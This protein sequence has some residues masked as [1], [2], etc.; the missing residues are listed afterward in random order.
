MRISATLRPKQ[1]AF[2]M[3]WAWKI[4]KG[5]VDPVEVPP[6]EGV[7]ICWVHSSAP[8]SVTAARQMVRAFGMVQVAALNSRHID[9]KAVD[10]TIAWTGR[11]SIDG[12]DG[13]KVQIA[14]GP[15]NGSN[16]RLITLGHGYKVIKLVTDPPHWSDDGR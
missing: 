9:G 5:A 10:M 12:T 14:D 7:G 1:R 2:L 4:A 3:H 16:P 6:M 11:L 13:V 15:R 8:K